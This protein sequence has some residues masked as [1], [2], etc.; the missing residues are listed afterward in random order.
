MRTTRTLLE[1]VPLAHTDWKP[2]DKSMAL[3]RLASHIVNIVT[4]GSAISTQAERNVLGADG[5]PLPQNSYSSSDE[6]LA[7]F[8]ANVAASRS[9]MQTLDEPQL[10]ESWTV[11]AGDRVIFTLPRKVALRNFLMNH[12]IHH[13]GQLSVYL[14]LNDVPLPSIYGPT[15]DT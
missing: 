12:I 4:F 7:A 9:A 2:H 14:R 10:K 1:R 5:K 6:L 13:R 3:G 15:A 8:D 11:R